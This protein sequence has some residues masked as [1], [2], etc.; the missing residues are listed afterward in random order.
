[1]LLGTLLYDIKGAMLRTSTYI[2][3]HLVSIAINFISDQCQKR[4]WGCKPEMSETSM[5]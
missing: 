4:C 3:L 2:A 5:E 1:M